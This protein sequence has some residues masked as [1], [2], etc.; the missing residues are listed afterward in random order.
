MKKGENERVTFK[1][2]R[3][4]GASS[5][6]EAMREMDAIGQASQAE[7]YIYHASI[8]PAASEPLTPDQMMQ[9][10]DILE[11]H[12]K[13]E[14]HARAIVAHEKA[15]REHYHIAWLRVD[16]ET[17]KAVKMSHNYRAHEEAAREIERTFG[18]EL[19]QGRHTG[20]G[21]KPERGPKQWESDRGRRSGLDPN[22]ISA[23]VSEVWKT[24]D[25]AEAFK[26]EIEARGY[27]LAVGKSRTFLLVDQNGDH[28]ALARRAKVKGGEVKER[29]ASFDRESLPSLEEARTTLGERS[30]EA[31]RQKELEKSFGAFQRAKLQKM[32]ND[33]EGF[34]DLSI[35]AQNQG[36]DLAS[37]KY[38]HLVAVAGNGFSYRVK[39]TAAQSAELQELQGEGL[40]LPSLEA[41]REERKAAKASKK[42]EREAARAEKEARWA[43]YEKRKAKRA[44]RLGSTLYDRGDMASQQQDA[45]LH[46]KDHEKAK[47]AAARA[48]QNETL[49][50]E[51]AKAAQKNREE[52]AKAAQALKPQS[53]GEQTDR[54][55]QYS[56]RDIMQELFRKQFGLPKEKKEQERGNDWDR[57]RER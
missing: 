18:L 36:F 27:L 25:N 51:K 53:R 20:G 40:I 9:A 31:D 19:T 6:H 57:E 48:Q 43:E 54:K 46:A 13:L 3:G 22:D 24:T 8:N 56:Q 37:N 28:H 2:V 16:P 45:L 26:A 15:G 41:I 5:L 35:A 21:P 29:F 49:Q 33:N 42:A 4:L 14:G 1:E 44:A 50:Q 47:R 52:R 55:Q 34:L 11:R 32:V 23:E 30:A 39:P 10:V 12:L 17:M 7:K 38:G